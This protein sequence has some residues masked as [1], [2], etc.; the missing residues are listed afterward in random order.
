MSDEHDRQETGHRPAR[1]QRQR[2]RAGRGRRQPDASPDN[3]IEVGA[4]L[5]ALREARQL[6]IRALAEQSGLAVN[7][8]SLIEN[9]KTSPSVSTLQ[10]LATTLDVPITAFFERE[11]PVSQVVYTRAEQRARVAFDQGTLEDLGA[12]MADC[13][14]EPFLVTLAPGA[15]SGMDMI[16][17]TGHEFVLCLTGHIAYTV[18][19]QRYRL[20][21]GDSLLFEAHEPHRWQNVHSARSEM[22]VLFCPSRERQRPEYLHFASSDQD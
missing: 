2:R 11:M 14:V 4:A 6:S 19:Q 3:T 5:R 13:P 7:T 9:G 8:L 10:R 12:G 20:K 1:Q 21:P 22:L 18:G 15:S 16:T 17:H